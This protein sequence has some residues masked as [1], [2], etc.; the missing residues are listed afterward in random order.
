MKKLIIIAAVLLTALSAS[1]QGIVTSDTTLNKRYYSPFRVSVQGGYAY[2]LGKVDKS[3]SHDMA[4]YSKKLSHGYSYGA[5][6]TWFFMENIGVGIKY[7]S[8]HISN[9]AKVTASYDD[10]S[11]Q[12]GEIRDNISITFIGPFASF[13]STSRNSRH[14]FLANIGL[15]YMGYKDNAVLIKPYVVKGADAG[16]LYELGYDYNISDKIAVGAILSYIAG[17]LKQARTNVSGNWE[18]LTLEEGQYES[19]CHFNL[20]IGLRINL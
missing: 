15:G 18:T 11:K 9:S 4:D 8:L 6:V 14:T 7:N 3:L 10:G 20:S 17:N 16:L 1:A 13:R 19:M 5:D 2:R 12:N